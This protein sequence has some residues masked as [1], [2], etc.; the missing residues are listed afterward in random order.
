[1]SAVFED[2]LLII[3]N[4]ITNKEI[5]R[6][7]ISTPSEVNSVIQTSKSYK[8]W[9]SLS[10]KKRC[11][12]ITQLR[13]QILKNKS[14]LESIIK[15]ETGKKEFDI[16]IEIFTMLEHFKQI[17]KIA[18]RALRPSKRN[19]GIMKSKKAY[20]LFEPL[21]VAGIISPWNYPLTTPVGSTIQA[22]LAGN[23]VVLKPSEHTPL[24]ALYIKKLW[25]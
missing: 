25:D 16:F 9:S 22:L 23:N 8:D 2:Q 13:K 19:A 15:S 20:V 6:L 17:T 1:M 11:Y 24:T 3:N 12:Y 7:P 21:G 18:K 14:E 10:L 4:P 5:S